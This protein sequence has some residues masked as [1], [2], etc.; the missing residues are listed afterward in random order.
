VK[1]KFALFSLIYL[2]TFTV[3]LAADPVDVMGVSVGMPLVQLKQ[4]LQ[5]KGWHC[6]QVGQTGF[7]CQTQGAGASLQDIR[8]QIANAL[9]NMPVVAMSVS[10]SS[11]ENPVPSLEQK[12]GPRTCCASSAGTANGQW[13][14]SNGSWIELQSGGTD[15]VLILKNSDL[16]NANAEAE[17]KQAAPYS[18]PKF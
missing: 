7:R 2:C 16:I 15:H 13:K 11:S 14:L 4:L 8:I 5:A 6:D 18:T 10:F 17:Q 1:A 12:F 9:P 3:G